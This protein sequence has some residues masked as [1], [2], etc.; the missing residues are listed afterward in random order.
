[1]KNDNIEP[2]LFTDRQNEF[3]IINNAFTKLMADNSYFNV[4]SFYGIGGIGKSRLIEYAFQT[5][6]ILNHQNLIELKINLEI[7]K[8]DNV[9][10]AILD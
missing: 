7:V 9:L 6:E 5:S 1:M 8:S 3:N 2:I 4:L 10:N